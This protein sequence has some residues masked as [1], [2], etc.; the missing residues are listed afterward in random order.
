[1]RRTTINLTQLDWRP[2]RVQALIDVAFDV[3]QWNGNKRSVRDEVY[4]LTDSLDVVRSYPVKSHKNDETNWGCCYYF[5]YWDGAGH[6][7]VH[8]S[9]I[10]VKPDAPERTETLAHEIAHALTAGVHGFTWRKMYAM[11][12]PLAYDAVDPPLPGVVG[13]D[14]W[15]HAIPYRVHYV[16]RRYGIRYESGYVQGSDAFAVD[17]RLRAEKIDAEVARH[18]RSARRCYDVFAERLRES[19]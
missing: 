5:S 10:Y 16:V 15:R 12:L 3:A 13:D 6:R 14:P 19:E 7:T 8:S 11:L 17:Y 4:A 18:M 9:V 2:E 1:M